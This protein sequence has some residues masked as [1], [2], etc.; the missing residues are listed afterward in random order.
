LRKDVKNVLADDLYDRL[1]TIQNAANLEW[2]EDNPANA[3]TRADF[4]IGKFPPK[5]HGGNHVEPTPTPT[6]TPQAK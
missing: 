1:Q 3:Q 6:P 4:R 2:P 5:D